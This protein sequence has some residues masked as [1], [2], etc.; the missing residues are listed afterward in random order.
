MIDSLLRLFLLAPVFLVIAWSDHKRGLV[1]RRWWWVLG[2]QALLVDLHHLV[3]LP[4]WTEYLLNTPWGWVEITNQTV[5]G[6]L[7]L[8]TMTLALLLAVFMR[9][10][11]MG[12]ADQKYVLVLALWY[13]T[14][15][16]FIL[17]CIGAGIA[18]ALVTH[19]PGRKSEIP[20]LVP[21][22]GAYLVV[23]TINIMFGLGL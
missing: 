13:P 17:A 23:A 10:A 20:F 7:M 9:S 3:T 8:L 22:V 4:V 18:F 12:P 2:G 5:F 11:R 6:V 15:P 16:L 21:L 19:L 14:Q 1:D